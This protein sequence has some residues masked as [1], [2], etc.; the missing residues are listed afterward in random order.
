MLTLHGVALIA[1]LFAA[2]WL[3][4][5]WLASLS[6]ARHL[7]WPVVGLLLWR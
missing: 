1:E 7:G 4:I 2:I 5:A 3:A 6:G